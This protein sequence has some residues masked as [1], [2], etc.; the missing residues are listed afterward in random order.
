VVRS[1]SDIA[2]SVCESLTL[3]HIQLLGTTGEW[4]DVPHDG[5]SLKG[6]RAFFREKMAELKLKEQELR[7]EE[8]GVGELR[9]DC[10][11]ETCVATRRQRAWQHDRDLEEEN[12]KLELSPLTNLGC[13]AN[14]AVLDNTT[15]ESG[16]SQFR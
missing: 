11:K 10:L 8:T 9:A 1:G 2:T 13:E 4:K 6:V 15:K 12:P 7:D 14:M 5:R 3:P 16:R